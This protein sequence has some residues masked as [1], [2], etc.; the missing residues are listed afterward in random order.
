MMRCT[1][2]G[3]ETPRLTVAQRHCPQCARE[4]E[5]LLRADYERRR[6]RFARAK[7]LTEAL[8]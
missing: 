8:R 5:Q 6:P 7:D 2:C 4:V 1:R 3:I